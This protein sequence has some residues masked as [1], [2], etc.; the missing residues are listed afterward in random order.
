MHL[1]GLERPKIDKHFYI[2]FKNVEN[3]LEIN[4]NPKVDYS[5]FLSLLD[6]KVPENSKYTF[7]LEKD[8]FFF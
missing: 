8:Y 2:D 3:I 4:Q 5:N 6:F 1:D 7:R